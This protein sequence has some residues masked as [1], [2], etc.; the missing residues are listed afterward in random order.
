[1]VRQRIINEASEL[2]G[3]IGVKSVTMD[4]FD[5]LFYVGFG[6]WIVQSFSVQRLPYQPLQ[7]VQFS[8]NVV[9]R[10]DCRPV[11][12]ASLIYQ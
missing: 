7:W 6:P 9:S 5:Q 1:M 2:F 11:E 3:Q 12:A 8:D 4:D 10:C